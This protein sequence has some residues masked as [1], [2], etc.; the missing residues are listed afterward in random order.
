M[1]ANH[2][3]TLKIVNNEWIKIMTRCQMSVRVKENDS[4]DFPVKSS[5]RCQ[6]NDGGL[7]AGSTTWIRKSEEKYCMEN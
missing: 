2:H 6:L 1:A 5:L 7:A 3:N 4:G